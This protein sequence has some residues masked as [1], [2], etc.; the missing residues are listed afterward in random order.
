MKVRNSE[1]IERVNEIHEELKDKFFD[2]IGIRFENKVRKVGDTCEESKS[3]EG[4]E[5]ERDFPEFGSEEYEELEDAGGTSAYDMEFWEYTLDS[6]D[7]TI[8]NCEHIYLIGDSDYFNGEDQGELI[9]SDA[10]VLAVV[11]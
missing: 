3:N 7:T 5:D 4:R 11:Q 6:G 1:L 2:S 10:K 8:V 9:F